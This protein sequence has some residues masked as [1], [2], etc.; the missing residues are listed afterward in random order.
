MEKKEQ[1]KI[2]EKEIKQLRDEIFRRELKLGII[3]P[4][5]G[6]GYIVRRET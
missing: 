1:I 5:S 4:K 3:V 2:L 6:I